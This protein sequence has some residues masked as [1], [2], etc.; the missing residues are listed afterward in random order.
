[1]LRTIFFMTCLLTLSAIG[2]CEE[3]KQAPQPQLIMSDGPGMANVNA[4]KEIR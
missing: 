4:W 3:A 1:M 2:F